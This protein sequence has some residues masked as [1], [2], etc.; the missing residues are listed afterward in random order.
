MAG[1]LFKCMPYLVNTDVVIG[2]LANIPKTNTPFR[3]TRISHIEEA[4]F[5][6]IIRYESSPGLER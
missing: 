5:F 2:H 3:Q 6:P 1:R 4:D